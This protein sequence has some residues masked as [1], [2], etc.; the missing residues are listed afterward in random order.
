MRRCSQSSVP[1]V[2]SL[3]RTFGAVA[4]MVAALFMTPET[5]RA[6]TTVDGDLVAQM[7]EQQKLISVFRT[8]DYQIRE[9]FLIVAN[10]IL[11]TYG[12]WDSIDRLNCDNACKLR[13]SQTDFEHQ[14]FLVRRDIGRSTAITEEELDGI[15]QAIEAYEDLIQTGAR[16][17]EALD[18]GRV[19]DANQIYFEIARPAYIQVHGTM[20]TLII[21]AERRVAALARSQRN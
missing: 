8:H 13:L 6:Q 19:D 4:F 17:A 2:T 16:I 3:A 7:A 21:K 12:G 9:H 1:A 10:A 14:V 5:A 15:T 11:S 18:D 20:Y